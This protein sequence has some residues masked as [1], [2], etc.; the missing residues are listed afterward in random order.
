MK[1]LITVLILAVALAGCAALKEQSAA[2]GTTAQRVERG[3]WSPGWPPEGGPFPY[4]AQ[5]PYGR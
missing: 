5:A 2:A 3:P 4:N 1:P